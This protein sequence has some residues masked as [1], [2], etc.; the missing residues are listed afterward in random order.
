MDQCIK[1]AQL[2]NSKSVVLESRTGEKIALEE[3]LR[4]VFPITVVADHYPAL[5]FQARQFLRAGTPD[6]IAAPLVTDVFALDSIAE[7]L[8]SPLRFLSYIGFRARYSDKLTASHENMLL[9]YHLKKNLWLEPDID[10]LWIQDDVSGY[11]DAAM[12]VR[13]EGLPGANTPDGI[14]TRFDGTLFERI[15][16]EIEDVPERPAMGLGLMLLELSEE[17]ARAVDGFATEILKRTVAD[18]RLHDASMYITTAA[19]GLTFHSRTE[20]TQEGGRRLLSHCGLRKYVQKAERW[21][22]VALRQDGALVFVVEVGG[23]WKRNLGLEKA[24]AK[25]PLR[26]AIEIDSTSNTGRREAEE[27]QE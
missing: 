17:A 16:R 14:L 6:G 4:A 27:R 10:M 24:V 21:F 22:G 11:L 7:M 26:P 2:L 20:W 5:A 13:R 12:Y 9:S 18:G 19:T 25:M 15:I 3:Q 8:E 1:C 23:E